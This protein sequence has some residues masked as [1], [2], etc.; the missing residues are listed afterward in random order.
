MQQASLYRLWK[1]S[2]SNPYFTIN[3]SLR[4]PDSL[5]SRWPGSVPTSPAAFNLFF[6]VDRI[7]YTR[8]G[9]LQGREGEGQAADVQTTSV[10]FCWIPE[11][12]Y[13]GTLC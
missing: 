2:F 1:A 12:D 11:F 3:T 7:F 5:L 13:P 9:D 4:K 10:P 8:E 6:S